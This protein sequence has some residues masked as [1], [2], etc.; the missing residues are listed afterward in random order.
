M[1]KKKTAKKDEPKFPETLFVTQDKDGNDVYYMADDEVPN[2]DGAQVA[3]Y[4]LEGVHTIRT[5]IELE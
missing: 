5:R 4:Q 1:A 3:I 2:T